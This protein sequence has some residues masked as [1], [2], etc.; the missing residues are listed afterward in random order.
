[1]Q[2]ALQPVPSE[3]LPWW[4]SSEPPVKKIS[5]II[6]VW[7]NTPPGESD[8]QALCLGQVFL[9]TEQYLGLIYAI[10]P[11]IVVHKTGIA[12]THSWVM[13]VR[14]D[15]Q[16][17]KHRTRTHLSQPSFVTLCKVNRKLLELESF[18]PTLRWKKSLSWDISER[19]I[20]IVYNMNQNSKNTLNTNILWVW[21]FIIY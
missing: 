2:S 19:K 14:S 18:M 11:Y 13:L 17:S 5:R 15:I 7:S 10:E 12:I 1:M 8:R 6:S 9:W 21:E 16:L 3:C 4:K 20:K